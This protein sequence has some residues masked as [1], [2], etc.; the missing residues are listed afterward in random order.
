[1][2]KIKEKFVKYFMWISKEK[3]L[4]LCRLIEYLSWILYFIDCLLQRTAMFSW[5]KKQKLFMM[6]IINCREKILHIL[7]DMEI[8]EVKK[9]ASGLLKK[10]NNITM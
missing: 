7:Y 6:D 1:M 9:I 10:K 8:I 4:L 2:I 3:K 5:W